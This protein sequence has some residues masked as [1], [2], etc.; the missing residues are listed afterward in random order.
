MVQF[1]ND[2]TD[3]AINADSGE[4]LITKGILDIERNTEWRVV[5]RE[6][7]IN[8]KGVYYDS[9]K[10]GS[11]FVGVANDAGTRA[12][13]KLQLRPLP[14]DEGLIIRH[15]S[16]RNK[17]KSVRT[18]IVFL[19]KAWNKI[20]GYGFIILEDV[21]SF[22]RLWPDVPPHRDENFL[23]HKKFLIEFLHNVLPI[24]PMLPKPLIDVVADGRA[25]FDQYYSIAS[26]SKH[27]HIENDAVLRYKDMYFAR[28]ENMLVVD[29][30]FSHAHLTGIDVRVDVKKEEF[31]LL[32][33]LY[34]RWVPT[35]QELVFPTWNALMHI[36]ND[37][38]TFKD[39][40]NTVERWNLLWSSGLYDH[41]PT[42]QSFYW[43]GLLKFAMNTIMLDLGASEWKKGD[44]KS[45]QALL[46]C[47]QE[48][49][50]WILKNK[51]K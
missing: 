16:D 21:S 41:D 36:H 26:A 50:L 34:W 46:N 33:N 47:W 17:S 3:N 8:D 15:V 31:I 12:V 45:K 38:L 49:F 5:D 39:F 25:Q 37:N 10:V 32:A 9:A 30:H 40:L 44:E 27:H 35:Y 1:G 6:R 4:A 24:E 51:F 19:D 18:P 22:P 7:F 11:F 43:D 14:F 42:A 29:V 13:L 28:L 23:N 48:F 2:I 20:D